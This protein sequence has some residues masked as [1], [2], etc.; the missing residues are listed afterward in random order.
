MNG[1]NLGR[2]RA[3]GCFCVSLLAGDSEEFFVV[4][5]ITPTLNAWMLVRENP[6]RLCDTSQEHA[7][8]P[9]VF[10]LRPFRWVHNF[11]I[12]QVVHFDSP[13]CC[14]MRK[15]FSLPTNCRLSTLGVWWHNSNMSSYCT[16]VH[17]TPRVYHKSP[18]YYLLCV[19]QLLLLFR[20]FKVSSSAAE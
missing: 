18:V 15:N 16:R 17:H 7:Y 12:L 9:I 6:D 2:L 11:M 14:D 20:T 13:Y 1:Q 19:L 5:I 4:E 8:M 10:F 3:R